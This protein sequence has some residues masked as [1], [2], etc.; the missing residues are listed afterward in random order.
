LSRTALAR[1]RSGVGRKDLLEL[2]EKEELIKYLTD[3]ELTSE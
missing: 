1:L 3:E 2:F